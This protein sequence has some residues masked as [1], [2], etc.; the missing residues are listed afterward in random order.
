MSLQRERFARERRQILPQLCSW[1]CAQGRRDRDLAGQEG[2]R[3]S[4]ARGSWDAVP[5]SNPARGPASVDSAASFA[6][7]ESGGPWKVQARRRSSWNGN[8]VAATLAVFFLETGV[9]GADVPSQMPMQR[10]KSYQQNLGTTSA[11]SD[12]VRALSS[13]PR[14]GDASTAHAKPS[15]AA[16]CCGTGRQQLWVDHN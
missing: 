8:M 2:G 5:R 11:V 10:D 9:G 6:G 15:D 4:M 12:T 3:P 1:N 14:C 16:S 7:T 13:L